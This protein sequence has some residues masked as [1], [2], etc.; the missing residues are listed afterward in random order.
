MS[1]WKRKKEL[2][3]DR[4]RLMLGVR[5]H[6]TDTKCYKCQRD[7]CD[8]W[9]QGRQKTS[10]TWK[11]DSIWLSAKEYTGLALDMNGRENKQGQ[12]C[13]MAVHVKLM[14]LY[15]HEDIRLTTR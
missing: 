5:V 6:N 7:I 4:K 8:T 13:D 1:I 15:D 10:R 11:M 3:N 2:L 9:C 14:C 12:G